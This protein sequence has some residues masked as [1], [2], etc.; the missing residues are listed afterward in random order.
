MCFTSFNVKKF[1]KRDEFIITV[2]K[3]PKNV[4]I[5]LEKVA[6]DIQTIQY[7]TD[8]LEDPSQNCAKLI[9]CITEQMKNCFP[10]RKVKFNKYRHKI[11]PW[12][13]NGILQSMRHRD[14]LYVNMHKS[15][16]NSENRKRLETELKQLQTIL[17]KTIRQAKRLHF[18]VEF[19]KFSGNCR[20]TWSVISDIL[21]KN[22]KKAEFPGHFIVN[23]QT[24][25]NSPNRNEPTTIDIKITDKQTIAD[26]FNVFFSNIGPTLSK[27]I[28]YNGNKKVENFLNRVIHS[29]FSFNLIESDEDMLKI[30]K[31]LKIKD[32]SGIDQISPRLLKQLAPTIHPILR[33]ITNQSISTGIFP[34]IF[35]L[36]IVKPLFKNKG[37]NTIFGNYRPISLLSSISK[38]IER[39]VFDQLYSYMNCNKLIE[40]SQYGFRK[41][42]STE[43][44]ALNFVDRTALEMDHNKFPI[45][46]F[47]DL[48]KAFDTL[49]HKILL[50]KLKFYGIEGTALNWFTSYLTNRKQMVDFNGTKSTTLE[51]KTGVPQGSI[52]GPLLFIIYMNDI[53]N[54]SIIFDEVLF[55]DDTSLIST[56]CKF[57][58]NISNGINKHD[59]NLAINSEL[60]KIIEWLN[61]NKLSLN[62]DKTKFMVFQSKRSSK[63][64]DWIELT[65][66]GKRIEKV[67]TFCF[68]GLTINQ[69]LD[70]DDH[71]KVI[72]NKISSTVGVLNKLKYILSTSI[73]KLIYSSLILSRIHYCNIVW[74]YSPKRITILQKKAVR[75]IC[76]TKYNAHTGPLFKKLNLLTVSDIHICKKLCFF[77]KFENNALPLYFYENIFVSN[78]LNRTR[79]ND[80]SQ[81]LNVK[82]EVFK[83]TIRF[84]LPELL[85]EIPTIIKSKVYTHS[86]DGFKNYIKKYFIKKYNEECTIINC[87]VCRKRR[88]L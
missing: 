81:N 13:T 58:V 19:T 87:F 72:S 3:S 86:Y 42:H 7:S 37:E 35:K 9:N 73:L 27:S 4:G 60:D 49:D 53:T 8:L 69:F 1:K 83:L 38:I 43:H 29:K 26:Q 47:L 15:P 79:N 76:R 64:F 6:T 56:L 5:F 11:A 2:D 20:K 24:S 33:I 36:A 17:Q 25:N 52:L 80:L 28:N 32:S 84:S 65:M 50:Q 22:R 51:I 71:I 78:V 61:I 46:V 34:E 66:N 67:S 88:Y 82:K 31:N 41:N 40:K 39:V 14:K 57:I 44:A 70:W 21:N 30:M 10:E 48:S 55:A 68:L 62:V 77:F 16:I 18:E 59:T 63:N 75:A 85:K 45:A 23:V 54:V 74:G 12:M